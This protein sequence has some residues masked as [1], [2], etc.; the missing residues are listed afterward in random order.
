MLKSVSGDCKSMVTSEMQRQFNSSGS[1]DWSLVSQATGLSMRKC[2][3][4]S[5]Y[6]IGKARWHYDLDTFSQSMV[7]QITRFISE[8]YLVPIP[9]NYQAV[10]S[11]MWVVMEDCIH[12]HEMLQGKFKWT[13]GDYRQAAALRG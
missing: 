5:L 7:D 1:V 11:F 6:G 2:L 13:K 12:I 10:S 9:T 3:E 8:H 4:H